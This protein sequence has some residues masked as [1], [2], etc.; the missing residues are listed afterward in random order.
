VLS[1]GKKFT[2]LAER[3]HRAMV[4]ANEIYWY[5]LS[6]LRKYFYL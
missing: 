6:M 3:H 2:F 4:L 5:L 1:P